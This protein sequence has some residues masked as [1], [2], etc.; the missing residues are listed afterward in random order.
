MDHSSPELLYF[1]IL[2]KAAAPGT[3]VGLRLVIKE[4][5]GSHMCNIISRFSDVAYTATTHS[6]FCPV[7]ATTY[8]TIAEEK[9]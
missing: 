2:S 4:Q 3:T 6:V 9:T 8:Q 5:D 7:L 1:N